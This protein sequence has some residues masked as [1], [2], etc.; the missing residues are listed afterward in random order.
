M[1][2]AGLVATE[3][4]R[5]LGVGDR[6]V[7]RWAAKCGIRLGNG[8]P[9]LAQ[10]GDRQRLIQLNGGVPLCTRGAPYRLYR[11]QKKTALARGVPWEITFPEWLQVWA[12]SGN[13]HLRGNRKG[14]YCM[15]RNGDIGPY[16]VGNVRIALFEENSAEAMPNFKLKQRMGVA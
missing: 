1:A 7:R 8:R 12:E 14:L 11:I 4:A 5:Q 6:T 9:D 13:L 2:V 10:G 16:K 15:A 3:I